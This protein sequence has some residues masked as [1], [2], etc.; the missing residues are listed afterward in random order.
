MG[1]QFLCEMMVYSKTECGNG[2]K[3]LWTYLK[4][5]T[6]RLYKV[7]YMII[8][9]IKVYLNKAIFSTLFLL[10]KKLPI[11][12]TIVRNYVFIYLPHCTVCRILFPWPGIEPTP[13]ALQV[14]SLNLWTSKEVPEPQLIFQVKVLNKDYCTIWFLSLHISPHNER[15]LT[16]Y[17]R[18]GQVLRPE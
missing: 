3:P 7:T 6:C 10:F 1:M 2:E 17:E 8:Y 5:F 13:P 9:G 18:N 15:L 16:S 4:P 11:Y 12:R 14:G